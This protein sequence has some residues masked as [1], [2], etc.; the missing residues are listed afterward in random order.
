[1]LLQ[2]AGFGQLQGI[3]SASDANN[4]YA[5]LFA[6]KDGIAVGDYKVKALDMEVRMKEKDATACS[7]LSISS[8]PALPSV[9]SFKSPD[10]GD[11][12]SGLEG[13]APAVIEGIVQ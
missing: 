10:L 3:P 1:M 2:Y 12:P 9:D 5:P 8:L 4:H 11:A 13:E 6:L 7:A